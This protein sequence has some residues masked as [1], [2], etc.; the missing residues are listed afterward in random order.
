MSINRGHK[1]RHMKEKFVEVAGVIIDLAEDAK[2]EIIGMLGR[3]G[4]EEASAQ[5]RILAQIV[6]ERAS[7]DR[8]ARENAEYDFKLLQFANE[9]HLNPADKHLYDFAFMDHYTLSATSRDGRT[10]Y[11]LKSPFLSNYGMTAQAINALGSNYGI[12][13]YY[14]EFSDKISRLMAKK[15]DVERAL[16]T[17][18]GARRDPQRTGRLIFKP[19]DDMQRLFSRN[20]EQ[21]KVEAAQ[22]NIRIINW[23]TSL[24]SSK[25]DGQTLRAS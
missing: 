3:L 7:A 6:H 2:S 12:K 13:V 19:D 11:E 16:A 10:F 4:I 14:Y 24:A 5:K 8:A 1:E 20:F 21:A 18:P 23:L 17:F 9:R 22:F 15:E 25:A